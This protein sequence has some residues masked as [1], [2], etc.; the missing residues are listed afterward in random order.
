M[1]LFIF[2]VLFISNLVAYGKP[3]IVGVPRFAPP[4]SSAIGN[5]SHYFGFCIDL[6]DEL[7]ARM[8]ENCQYK[9]TELGQGQINDLNRG[10]IDLTFLTKPLGTTNN[11]NY[12]Y[13]LPYIPSS[14]QFLTLT[15]SNLHSLEAL[16]GK[17]I[18]VFAANSLKNTFLAKYT[19]PE[20]IYEY[21]K[22]MDMIAALHAHQVDAIL[23]NSSVAKYAINNIGNLKPLGQPMQL[24]MGYGI[25][26]LKKNAALIEKIN[27]ALLQLEAD[28]TY[29]TIYKKY[30]GN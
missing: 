12:L 18:G 8:H 17:K 5:S 7:C 27:K 21:D 22:I 10:L 9:T 30:F 13:S 11:A 24:G 23:M 28:G 26:S 16:S 19:A 20:N 1:K 2:L 29:T 14:G 25:I 15:N 6:M 4:F 3:L